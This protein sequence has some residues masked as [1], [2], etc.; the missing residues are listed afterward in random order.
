VTPVSTPTLKKTTGSPLIIP[1]TNPSNSMQLQFTLLIREHKSIS[2]QNT[3]VPKT[4][5]IVDLQ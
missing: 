3:T 5:K 4:D 2:F 1:P